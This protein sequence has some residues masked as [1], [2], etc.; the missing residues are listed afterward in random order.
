MQTHWRLAFMF[1]ALDGDLGQL[2][3]GLGA[4]VLHAP[5]PVDCPHVA[6]PASPVSGPSG[7]KTGG[8]HFFT[9]DSVNRCQHPP[10]AGIST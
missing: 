7:G 3:A 8:E 10:Q 5:P 1:D 4:P 2:V 9:Q 6:H